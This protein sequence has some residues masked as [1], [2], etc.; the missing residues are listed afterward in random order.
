MDG[1]FFD[2]RNRLLAKLTSGRE[3]SGG[4]RRRTRVYIE[5]YMGIRVPNRCTKHQP[6]LSLERSLKKIV[7][8]FN[9]SIDILFVF[10]D[11]ALQTT[12]SCPVVHDDGGPS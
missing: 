8:K 6:K 1:F 9:I 7:T 5:K 12:A 11:T 3:I 10:Q 4:S 2:S